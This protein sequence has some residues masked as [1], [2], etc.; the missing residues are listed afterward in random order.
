MTD[1]VGIK[2]FLAAIASILQ[3]KVKPGE[4]AQAFYGRLERIRQDAKDIPE[5][6]VNFAA[7]DFSCED[8]GQLTVLSTPKAVIL[9][10]IEHLFVTVPKAMPDNRVREVC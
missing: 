1:Q 8:N 3:A 10:T 5:P 7:I 9:L 6:M 4:S 2:T